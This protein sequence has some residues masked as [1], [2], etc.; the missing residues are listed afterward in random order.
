MPQ[1]GMPENAG[2]RVT[3]KEIWWTVDEAEAEV[4]R[5]NALADDEESLYF[6]Q[7]TRVRRR[8]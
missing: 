5:L 7:H 3:V 8:S 6:W 4:D 1:G 2:D